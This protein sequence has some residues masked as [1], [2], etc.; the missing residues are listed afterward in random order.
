MY[1]EGIAHEK[2]SATLVA[3]FGKRREATGGVTVSLG[4]D[5]VNSLLPDSDPTARNTVQLQ[6]M[7]QVAFPDTRLEFQKAAKDLRDATKFVRGSKMLAAL[8]YATKDEM[9][10]RVGEKFSSA[11]GPIKP[12][13]FDWLK[14]N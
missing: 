3:V 11:R 14:R 5:E 1:F 8:R 6:D 10:E 12:G 7:F 2:K 9:E 4:L 13:W